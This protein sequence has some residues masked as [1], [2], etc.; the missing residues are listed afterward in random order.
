MAS[1]SKTRKG[2]GVAA[3]L[4]RATVIRRTGS[5][6]YDFDVRDT[7]VLRSDGAILVKSQIAD[8]HHTYGGQW[9]PSNYSIAATIKPTVPSR[10]HP[11]SARG[12]PQSAQRHPVGIH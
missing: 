6:V 5:A 8:K 11:P 4:A 3:E 7:Y 10:E 1:I 12:I 2:N 9:R